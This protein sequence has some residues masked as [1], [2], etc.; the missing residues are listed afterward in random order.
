[1]DAGQTVLLVE[2]IMAVVA[3]LVVPMA[4]AAKDQAKADI[5]ILTV[6]IM[7]AVV[8]VLVLATVGALAEKVLFVSSGEQDAHS[9]QR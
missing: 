6:V 3:A 9:L 1:M 7:A 4:V 2:T 8:V 5:I